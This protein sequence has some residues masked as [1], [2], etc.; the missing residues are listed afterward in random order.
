MS[1]IDPERWQSLS[2]HLDRALEMESDERDAWLESLRSD[3]PTLVADL[4]ALLQERNVLVGEGFLEGSA[5]LPATSLVGQT[6]GPYRIASLI[7]QGGMGTVWRA[8]RADGRFEGQ[9]A[10]KLLNASLVGSA[11]EARF[12]REVRILARLTHPHIAHLIDA[13]V[14]PTG[15]LYLVLEYVDGEPIDEYC[16]AG[17]LGLQARIGL[18]R[19][20]VAAVAHAHANLIVHRDIK[21]SNVLVSRDGQVKLLDFG[22]AKLL[23]GG[24]P[25]EA[26]AVTRDG[27]R[28]LT[29]EYAAPEQ[30][31]GGPLTTA[32]DVYSLGA[33]LYLLL[34]GHHPAGDARRS[35]VDLLKAIVDTE[36]PRLSAV[37]TAAVGWPPEARTRN[38]AL[39]ATTPARLVAMLEGDLDTI[40]ARTLKKRPEERYASVGALGDDLRRYLD[41]EPIRARPDTLVYRASKFL[42]R[43]RTGVALAALVV[44]AL[45][46]GLVG[47]IT[48]ARQATA[49]RDFA[50]RQLSRAEAIND[51]NA[52]LLSDA[53][54]SGRPFT[55][56]ELLARAER[57]VERERGETDEN[58]VEMLIAIGRQYQTQDEN[59]KAVPLLGRAYDLAG[60]VPDLAVRAKAACALAGAIARNG[61]NERAE[62]LFQEGLAG[63]P[64]E[65]V[66]ALDRAFCLLRGSE[67]A[68]EAGQVTLGVERVQAA[69]RVL[70]EPRIASAS[71][72]LGA[73]M[74]LAEA[75]RMAGRS[76]EAAATFQEA[77]ERISA[78][79]RDD[80][81]R[82][83][84][85]LNNWALTVEALGRPLEAERLYRRAVAIGSADGTEKGV[86]PM[87][88]NNLARTLRD[89]SRL[90]EARDYA[91]RAYAG[92]R[93]A[94]DEVVI[95]QS[96]SERARTYREG[97][98]LAQ[99]AAALSELAPRL[100]RML[101][102]GHVA[103]AALELENAL[104]AEARGDLAAAK[105]GIDHAVAMAEASTQR[106]DYLPRTLLRRSELELRMG[107][108]EEASADAGRALGLAR[109]RGEPGTHSSWR[110]RSYLAVGRALQAEGRL[111]EARVALA[112]ALEDLE[113][114]LGPDHPD[115]RDARQRAA[116][117]AMAPAHLRSSK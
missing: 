110:G 43:N 112:S 18:V 33:L 63:L 57:V 62:K 70:T 95:N 88:L 68:R 84:T 74:D 75:Y 35:P 92:A 89:L 91:E 102:A 3:D 16:D 99:A 69:Q 38:A 46:A 83:G 67:V 26:T 37:V 81:E 4:E 17:S 48:E 21:P 56:G 58:R 5:P 86:S 28:V 54:P 77:F 23:E 6:L 10:V 101:P 11:G 87:L 90:S 50:L 45:V 40:V 14:S 65:A 79:G 53:A 1:R 71:A 19:D 27:S 113:P 61:E 30:V 49:Q 60:K 116:S 34:S 52:F 25:R 97:N 39:R 55:V 103:F 100:R 80:T 32:T 85:L 8:E 114:S 24:A 15:Q 72:E 36:A 82:A 66:F 47:T 111:A 31:T 44:L 9:V 106:A 22:I 20:V 93:Q 64:N 42:R 96:L 104:L 12:R 59:A 7:G 105:T 78:L 41:H 108:P 13:G 117:L 94:G 109:A 29:P 51:L 98:D 76:R 73:S 107:L 2:P 115:S